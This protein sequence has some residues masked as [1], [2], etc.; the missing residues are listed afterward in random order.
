MSDEPVDLNLEELKEL[1][2]LLRDSNISEFEL[3]KA[4]YH[5]K[6]KQGQVLEN[7]STVTTEAGLKSVG[8]S[9]VDGPVEV[10]E[11][12]SEEQQP[13]SEETEV[14]HEVRSPMV[15]TFFR[16]A[17]PETDP[18]V[19]IGDPV[20]RNQVLCIIEAMKIMNE[21]ESDM[22]GE[23]R[24]IHVT[25]GQPVEYGEVLFSIRPVS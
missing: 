24:K 4:D 2:K 11:S 1:I 15:G 9:G 13:K 25:N 8:A 6:I 5:L 22:E 23:V 12:A 21:I 14:L 19:E 3:Q 7:N 10:T 20:R 16:S 18:F 17:G